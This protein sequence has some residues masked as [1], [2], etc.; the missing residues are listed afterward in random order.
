MSARPM[1]VVPPSSARVDS[2]LPENLPQA[3]E[4][5]STPRPERRA[6]APGVVVDPGAVVPD[7]TKKPRAG[8]VEAAA[9]E[10]DAPVPP[11]DDGTAEFEDF[12]EEETEDDPRYRSG[13]D[14]PTLAASLGQTMPSQ[15]D[16]EESSSDG[17]G[18]PFDR[19]AKTGDPSSRPSASSS[20]PRPRWGHTMTMID[21]RRFVVYGGQAIDGGAASPRP[22][23]DLHVHDLG[24]GS[25]TRPINCDGVARAWHTAN[26]LPDRRLLLCFGGEVLDGATGRLTATDQVMVLDTESEQLCVRILFRSVWYYGLYFFFLPPPLFVRIAARSS[27]I[28]SPPSR[29]VMLWYPPTGEFGTARELCRAT[30]E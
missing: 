12:I 10:G 23:A 6:D 27:S 3:A 22:L 19:G 20:P 24:D 7:S 11:T 21:H 18:R 28:P 14:A 29:T 13:D 2:F 17:D 25:W 15:E 4:E 26:F 16:N 8:I 9:A 30:P 5:P 1:R